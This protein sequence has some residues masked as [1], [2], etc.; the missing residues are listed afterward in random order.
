[1]VTGPS[2]MVHLVH[3]I[4]LMGLLQVS[5]NHART[6]GSRKEIHI[7]PEA[8]SAPPR[9]QS[10]RQGCYL[11]R[12]LNSSPWRTQEAKQVGSCAS[13]EP[14][15]ARREVHRAYASSLLWAIV[16]VICNRHTNIYNRIIPLRRQSYLTKP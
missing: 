16:Y 9:R 8:L 15:A 10:Y 13:C 1:M 5:F 11:N 3:T 12:A 2:F 6:G 7:Y 14:P 4:Y